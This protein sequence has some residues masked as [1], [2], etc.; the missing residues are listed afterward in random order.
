MSALLPQPTIPGKA[1]GIIATDPLT[2]QCGDC[3]VIKARTTERTDAVF[4]ILARFLF[5][6]SESSRG[7]SV[8]R[9]PECMA[10]HAKTCARCQSP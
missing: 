4:I 10:E 5:C 3:G 1:P 8:R 9:C 6:L 2:I 7:S